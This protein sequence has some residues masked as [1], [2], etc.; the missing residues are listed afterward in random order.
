M[1]LSVLRHSGKYWIVR[2]FCFMSI[3][4]NWGVSDYFLSI[5][6]WIRRVFFLFTFLVKYF[7]HYLRIMLIWEVLLL[8]ILV[9]LNSERATILFDIHLNV[10]NI[11]WVCIWSWY[12][13]NRRMKLK[14]SKYINNDGMARYCAQCEQCFELYGSKF[15]LIWMVYIVWLLSQCVVI[16]D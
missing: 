15:L 11:L 2:T 5:F 12:W 7:D 16:F 6:E 9:G 13:N 3:E 8:S 1:D 14:Q 4:K 10:E